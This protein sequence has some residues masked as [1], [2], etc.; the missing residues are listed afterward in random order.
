[1]NDEQVER[2]RRDGYLYLPGFFSG[3]ETRAIAAWT[4]EV[5]AWPEEPGR[6]MVYHEDS[7]APS[8]GRNSE[9]A[10]SRSEFSGER[11][12]PLS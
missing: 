7:L 6:H 2:F 9:S 3:D 10:S 1:M 8:D 5:A 12:S 11:E 4:D